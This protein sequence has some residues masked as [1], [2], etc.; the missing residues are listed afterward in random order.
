MSTAP[1]HHGEAPDERE[2]DALVADLQR[3]HGDDFSQYAKASRQRRVLA[4]MRSERV[5]SVAALRQ[6]LAGD[7][8]CGARFIQALSVPATAM[9]RDPEVFQAIRTKVVPQLATYPSV[10]VWVAGCATGEEA[11]SLAIVLHEE[12]ILERTRIHATDMSQLAIERA[13][14]GIFPLSLMRDYTVNYQRSGGGDFSRYYTAAYGGA[15]FDAALRRNI[16][17]ARHNLASE[18][19]FNEFHLICCRNVLIYFDPVLQVRAHRLLHAS[20]ADL[21]FLCLGATE[22][23]PPGITRAYAAVDRELRLYRKAPGI[24]A[25]P[26]PETP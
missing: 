12:G 6:R 24:E 18:A 4:L 1:L 25:F 5:E 19:S 13:E 3:L 26:V 2:I 9:F 10:R 16:V 8:A 14:S 23:L 20:L 11:W 22:G 17:F 15:K 21:G 7:S